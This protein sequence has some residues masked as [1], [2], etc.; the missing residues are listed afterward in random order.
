MIYNFFSKKLYRGVLYLREFCWSR[1][2][3][4]RVLPFPARPECIAKRAYRGSVSKGALLCL[5]TLSSGVIHAGPREGGLKEKSAQKN[6]KK[7]HESVIA[8]AQSALGTRWLV[9]T[10]TS[11][12]MTDKHRAKKSKIKEEELV[13]SIGRR[14]F[15]I[16]GKRI[17]AKDIIIESTNG[18]VSVNGVAYKGSVVM[19]RG[20]RNTLAVIGTLEHT[21]TSAGASSGISPGNL[22]SNI[23]NPAAPAY[24]TGKN[25]VSRNLSGTNLVASR[26]G[27]RASTDTKNAGENKSELSEQDALQAHHH[28]HIKVLLDQLGDGHADQWRFKAPEGFVVWDAHYK[29]K[30]EVENLVV[31]KKNQHIYLNNKICDNSRDNTQDKNRKNNRVIAHIIPC[32]RSGDNSGHPTC[33]GKTYSGFFSIIQSRDAQN[34]NQFYL[35]NSVELED[36]IC[37]VL[38]TESL[39]SWPLEMQKVSAIACR[40]YALAMALRADRQGTFYHLKNT[41]AHQTYEGSHSNALMRQAV[42][43]TRGIFMAYN[44]EPAIAMYDVCCGGVIPAHMRDFNCKSAPYL[45]RK[46]ACT[47]C[48]PCK[49]YTWQTTWRLKDFEEL[50]SKKHQKISNITSIAITKK[51][52]AGIVKEIVLQSNSKSVT[53]SGKKLYSIMKGVK[54]FNFKIQKKGNRVVINGYGYGHHKGLCQWGAREMVRKGFGHEA[55]LLFYYPG[56]TFARMA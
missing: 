32:L 46:Y 29:R 16:N 37:G 27:V 12:V 22:D 19:R 2:D 49:V 51:D 21:H 56:I 4:S 36:Y 10:D 52:K 7:A 8:C 3:F 5:L 41:N 28:C 39:P 17:S 13:L 25:L 54:S 11:F 24:I 26:T 40:T 1:R 34:K 43:E 50:I 18:I 48:K 47:H 30:M 38:G 45:A 44:G 15:S 33:N 42:D 14:F 53:V 55:V 6:S 23:L 9:R 31:T 35:V 20:R